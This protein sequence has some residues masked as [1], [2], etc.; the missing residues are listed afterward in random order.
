MKEPHLSPAAPGSI[1]KQQGAF[2]T[3]PVRRAGPAL[4]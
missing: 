3:D 1:E 2:P 4:T